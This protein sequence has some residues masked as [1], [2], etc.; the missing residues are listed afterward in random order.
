MI[1][2]SSSEMEMFQDQRPD[3]HRSRATVLPGDLILAKREGVVFIPAIMAEKVVK[4]AEYIAMRDAFGHQMLREQR[5][6]PG[7]IDQKWTPAINAA[8]LKWTEEHPDQMKMTQPEPRGDDEAAPIGGAGRFRQG[9][10]EKVDLTLGG[11]CRCRRRCA[12][13]F[14]RL[15][16]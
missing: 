16:S 1:R 2:P 8:F 12:V 5:F 6:T 10:V 15:A 7:E 9:E 4:G 11:G 14:R 3:P 13:A